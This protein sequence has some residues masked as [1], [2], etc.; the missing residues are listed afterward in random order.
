MDYEESTTLM[1]NDG[2]RKRRQ[3]LRKKYGNFGTSDVCIL[4]QLER[5]HP[6]RQKKKV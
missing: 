5:Y 1:R 3:A 2:W 6:N 4:S